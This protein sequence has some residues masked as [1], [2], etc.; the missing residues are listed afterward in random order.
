MGSERT[1]VGLGAQILPP[2]RPLVKG[3]YW[4]EASQAVRQRISKN[5]SGEKRNLLTILGN[6]EPF[7]CR[8][9]ESI[10]FLLA[11]VEIAP[12]KEQSPCVP[13][14]ADGFDCGYRAC[15]T[16]TAAQAFPQFR[17]GRSLCSAANLRQQEIGK[18]HPAR[19]ACACKVRCTP[20][21]TLRT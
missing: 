16:R 2:P 15:N 6:I 20:S 19:A 14:E 1:A 18:R 4:L 3:R 17:K 10:C 12:Q 11:S 13:L 9:R 7:T 21:G 5:T 8:T